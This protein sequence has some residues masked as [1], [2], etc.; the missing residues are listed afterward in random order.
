ML[1]QLD[2][3]RVQFSLED[4]LTVKIAGCNMENPLHKQL[5]WVPE[6]FF[7]CLRDFLDHNRNLAAK[8]Q[9]E[10][11]WLMNTST[12]KQSAANLKTS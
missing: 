11:N 2:C 4:S 7:V 3:S 5:P 9:K 8:K 1:N 10:K 6:V 12:R